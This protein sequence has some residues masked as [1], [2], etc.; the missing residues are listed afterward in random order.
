MKKILAML[1]LLSITSNATE[2]F[3]EYYVMEKV[4][5][6]LTK[7]ESYTVNGEEVK[8]VKV[9]RK[10]LKALGTTDDPFYYTNSNQEKKLVRVGDYIVTPV[11]FATIDS[12]SSKEFNNNFTKK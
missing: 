3:S 7:A 1:A 9:D 10:V 5:P 6:L 4:L 12:A 2:V 11:T 8:A